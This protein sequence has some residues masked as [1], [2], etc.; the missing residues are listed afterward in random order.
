MRKIR[1]A[2]IGTSQNSHGNNILLSLLKQTDIFEVVG[3]ALP[4]NEREKFP[5]RAADFDG[6]R[7]MTVEEILADESIEAVVVETEEIYL[8]K[9]ALM[10]A[11]AGKHIHM[12]KPGGLCR[13][14]FHALI[15]AVKEKGLVFHTGYMYRYNP[16]IIALKEA[17]EKGELGDIVSI[18]THMCC[19]HTDEV[20]RWLG[21]FHGGMMFFLGCHLLDL[22][23]SIQGKPLRVLP[24]NKNTTHGEGHNSEDF[25]LALLE[26]EKG[27]SIVKTT[28]V[29]HGGF[30]RRH[31]T[32]V[33]T[34]KTVR[35]EPLEMFDTGSML[36]TGKTE[37]ASDA[38]GDMGSYTES[39]RFDRYDTMMA[40]F[41]AVVRGEKE[42][43]KSYDYEA[44]LYE[45]VLAACG[46]SGR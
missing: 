35:L 8:T 18:E 36:F 13:D 23:L 24:F 5:A 46:V 4:E 19:R 3:Y 31:L 20:L 29:E 44:E 27:Y 32:V 17:I 1:V 6:L 21:T 43:P 37:Y 39:A 9:Y 34:K 25:C 30:A 22:V 40:S 41:A 11:E 15:A 38:W 33:G 7:E 45:L 16:E 12:E 10:A 26:Y 42:S 28:A 14:G 2:Q